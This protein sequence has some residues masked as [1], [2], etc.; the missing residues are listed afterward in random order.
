MS[1]QISV[2][3]ASS[4]KLNKNLEALGDVNWFE[5]IVMTLVKIKSLAQLRLT[6]KGHIITSRLKNSIYIKTPKQSEA[7]TIA[8]RQGI[9]NNRKYSWNSVGKQKGGSGDR[10][11]STVNVKKDEGAVGTNVVYG[12]KIERMDSY[13]Y[14]ALKNINKNIGEYFRE[15]AKKNRAKYTK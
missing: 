10:D 2:D 12:G 11:L 3:K 14:W 9:E 7:N 13:L 4:N 5:G 15:V 8:S 6:D 1:V